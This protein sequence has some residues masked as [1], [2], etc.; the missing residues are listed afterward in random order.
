MHC[1]TPVARI[2]ASRMQTQA[3]ACPYNFCRTSNGAIIRGASKSK[4]GCIKRIF[5]HGV[6]A[7][8]FVI[9]QRGGMHSRRRRA[10]QGQEQDRQQIPEVGKQEAGGYKSCPAVSSDEDVQGQQ[11]IRLV[12]VITEPCWAL[13]SRAQCA[14][15]SEDVSKFHDCGVARGGQS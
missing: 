14:R 9:S 13:I 8:C 2:S 10:G 11:Q 4:Q 1:H 6:P 15:A 7:Q 3:N 5:C 12:L